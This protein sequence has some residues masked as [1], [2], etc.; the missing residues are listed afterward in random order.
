MIASILGLRASIRPSH[1]PGCAP[2]LVAWHTTALT[3]MMSSPSQGSFPIFEVT[4][5]FCLPPVDLWSG[6]S[7]SHP[8]QSRPL[9][10]NFGG[11]ARAASAVAVIG[12][13]PGMVIKWPRTSSVL[14]RL[15]I[16]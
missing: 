12:P 7:P 9:R 16:S 3:S 14:A 11:D 8:A 13:I 5:S 15:A 4:P 6:V 1:E 10:N 2:P